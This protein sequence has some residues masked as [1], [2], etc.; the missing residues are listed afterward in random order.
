VAHAPIALAIF[1]GGKQVGTTGDRTV[2]PPG[3]HELEFVGEVYEIRIPR[4]VVIEPGRRATIDVEIPRGSV[5]L[6]AQ[7]WAEVWAGDERLGETP[8]GNVSLPVGHYEFV[9]R[10]PQLG[11]RRA[12]AVVRASTPTRVAVSF[13]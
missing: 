1:E 13:E 11:E 5:S 6:N 2:L 3:R 7:P 10:H 8:L 9:F 12:T 4:A